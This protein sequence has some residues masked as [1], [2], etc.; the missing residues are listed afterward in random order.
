MKR[1]KRL[2]EVMSSGD[3]TGVPS[4][5]MMRKPD[6]LRSIGSQNREKIEDTEYEVE[7]FLD[8]DKDEVILIDT[9]TGKKELWAKRDDFSGYVIE[10]DGIGYE[11]VS[12][13]ITNGIEHVPLNTADSF[14]HG[15]YENT[16]LLDYSEGEED[17]D[18]FSPFHHRNDG[19]YEEEPNE[20]DIILSDAGQLGSKVSVGEYEGTHYGIFN[21][22]K[23]ALSA[24][25]KRIGKYRPSIWRQSDHGNFIL[26]DYSWD[27]I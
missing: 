14:A 25:K 24:V 23:E 21:S 18:V 3:V 7:K 5:S 16:T 2:T 11:F 20:G 8:D 27:A 10:I 9:E 22:E 19:L 17:E 4:S 12:S 15:V 6:T 1:K 13:K 26:T